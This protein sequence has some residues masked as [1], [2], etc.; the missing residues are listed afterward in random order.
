[1]AEIDNNAKQVYG[2]AVAAAT[3]QAGSEFTK[4]ASK[5]I[6]YAMSHAVGRAFQDGVTD[7]AHIKARMMHAR[8]EAKVFLRHLDDM[9]YPAPP[10]APEE[11]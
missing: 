2:T 11:N 5:V 4:Q 1:M 7:P 8:E 3:G 9:V 6:E 10:E